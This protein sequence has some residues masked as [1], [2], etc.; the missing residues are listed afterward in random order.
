MQ[1]N[2]MM[3]LAVALGTH[4]ALALCVLCGGR[5]VHAQGIPSDFIKIEVSTTDECDGS[6][7]PQNHRFKVYA[8][9]T[10][11]AQRIA[12]NIEMNTA[13]PT[14]R[15]E[16]RDAK[17][18]TYTEQ[19]PKTYEHRIAPGGR[20]QIGCTHIYR[21]DKAIR[22]YNAIP[23]SYSLAGATWVSPNLPVPPPEK[24]SDFVSA[25]VQPWEEN[26]GGCPAG[27]R[28]TG[29]FFL[30]NTHP[31]KRLA[32]KASTIDG[33]G[34]PKGFISGVMAPQ[35][36]VRATCTNADQVSIT[37]SEVY[38]AEFVDVGPHGLAPSDLNLPQ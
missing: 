36:N 35:S 21:T 20:T 30:T 8:T 37:I 24:G 3:R 17:L 1:P 12:A 15:F 4:L 29:V 23:L 11:T 32:F 27:G 31:R 33:N 6:T 28:P 38:E 22:G 34:R 2:P 14:R 7:A 13:P 5:E 9:N 26:N 16:L 18:M 10:H 19:Y 25:M